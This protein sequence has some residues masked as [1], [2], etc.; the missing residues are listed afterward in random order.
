MFTVFEIA[1]PENVCIKD[2]DR[3]EE[4]FC[5]ER[6]KRGAFIHLTQVNCETHDEAAEMVAKMRV[7][8][9]MLKLTR[10]IVEYEKGGLADIKRITG[11]THY[12][13]GNPIELDKPLVFIWGNIPRPD[14]APSGQQLFFASAS[15]SDS[16]YLDTLL[17]EMEDS[18][19][20]SGAKKDQD[21]QRLSM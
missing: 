10:F 9:S 16:L 13:N 19:I 3:V 21:E 8:R 11:L 5:L 15:A 6:I 1:F 4:N 14:S 17:P 7:S 20:L 2:Y 12:L 18:E